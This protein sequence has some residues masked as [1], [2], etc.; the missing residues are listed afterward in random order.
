[1]NK[2]IHKII[3]MSFYFTFLKALCAQLTAYSMYIL[4]VFACVFV[5]VTT[6]N[7]SQHCFLLSVRYA[8]LFIHITH[9]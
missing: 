2:H 8:L 7:N 9:T 6:L 3:C 5:H 4:Y 1:M